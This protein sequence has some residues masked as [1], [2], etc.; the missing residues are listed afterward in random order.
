MYISN[1]CVQVDTYT[2]GSLTPAGMS[3]AKVI[4]TSQ[5]YIY[6]FKNLKRKIDSCSANLFFNQG[7][8][9]HIL[10]TN[11]ARITILNTSKA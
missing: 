3:H 4:E 2:C 6:R 9:R 5:A 7:Y 10:I 11:Y 8:A 1:P